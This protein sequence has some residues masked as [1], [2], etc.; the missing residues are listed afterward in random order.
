MKCTRGYFGDYKFDRVRCRVFLAGLILVSLVLP[1]LPAYGANSWYTSV[2]VDGQTV[3]VSAFVD[4]VIPPSKVDGVTFLDI[5]ISIYKKF[6]DENYPSGDND[7]N[8]QGNPGSVEQDIYEEIIQFMAD[9]VY[10][11]TDG[12]HKLR[13]VCIYKKG[14]RSS[15]ADIIWDPFGIP[16]ATRSGVAGAG[17]HIYMYDSFNGHDHLVDKEGAGYGLAHNVGHYFYGLET[18]FPQQSGDVGVRFSIMNNPWAAR[19]GNYSWLNF[20]VAWRDDPPGDFEDTKLSE[21][22]RYFFESCWE[23]IARDPASDPKPSDL[24]GAFKRPYYT[25]LAMVAPVG[26]AK[27]TVDLPVVGT[28]TSR[29]DLNIIWKTNDLVYQIVLDRSGSMS[30]TKVENAKTAAKLLVGKAEFGKSSIGIVIFD[31]VVEVLTPITLIADQT[32]KD[33]IAL[34]IDT[35]TAGGSTAVGDAAQ[36]AL[37]GLTALGTTDDTKI[38]FLLSDGQSNSGVDPL[39]VIPAYQ[40]AKIPIFSFAYGS[41][42]DTVTLGQMATDT[43]GELFISPTS[44]ADVTSAFERAFQLASGS[45]SISS[46]SGVAQGAKA[47]V[48]NFFVIDSTVGRL[49]LSVVHDGA[50]ADTQ[51][52]LQAPTGAVVAPTLVSESTS[53]TLLLYTVDLPLTGLWTITVTPLVASDVGFTYQ[54][55][56]IPDGKQYS[57]SLESW[58]GNELV[59]PAPMLLVAALER[60]LPINGASVLG[61]LTRPSGARSGITLRDDGEGVDETANDGRYSALVIYDASGLYSIDIDADNFSG[62]ASLTFDD[63][64]LRP[65][66][67]GSDSHEHEDDPIEEFFQREAS[68]QLQVTGTRADDHGNSYSSAT[69]VVADNS[70]TP[71]RI[72]TLSDVD[73]FSFTVPPGEF[74]LNVRV[75]GLAGGIAPRLRVFDTNGITLLR[76]GTSENATGPG[77]YVN[78][79]FGVVAAGTTYYAS[80]SNDATVG[81][82]YQFSAGPDIKA[83]SDRFPPGAARNFMAVGEDGVVSL[84]WTEP[85]DIDLAGVRIIR[86]SSGFP[87][88]PADG[89]P[90][91]NGLKSNDEDGA[92]AKGGFFVDT[93]VANDITYYYGAFAYDT[94][95]NF[96]PGVY[97][98]ATPT[99][100]C[101]IAT[102]A[103]GSPLAA[104]LYLFRSFRDQYLMTNVVGEKLVAFYYATSPP[105]ADTIAAHAVLRIPVRTGLSVV[106]FIL[107]GFMYAPYTFLMLG[108]AACAFYVRRRG[109]RKWNVALHS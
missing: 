87:A 103:Y 64:G 82:L 65:P 5:V 109:S 100:P 42:A 59:Y 17:G 50:A 3:P 8:T 62:T 13:N 27:P 4:R 6:G 57:L 99:A 45:Q 101:F 90:V 12:Q 70:D 108:V 25:D 92:F 19:G 68:M 107:R 75:S 79:R 32:T 97:A 53:E 43:G 23:T 31:N 33:D 66:P 36:I 22:H 55:T 48:E 89:Q 73:F 104:D 58:G 106:A 102:A 60:E 56:S 93:A 9:G 20:S 11:S 54:A 78:L 52:T 39:S 37:D 80:V 24:N 38:V 10:E 83:D 26:F 94:S 40:S 98:S 85:T 35:I 18:E 7:G 47:S 29:S 72:E 1:T 51:I 46:E 30:G 74:R 76:E 49:D 16:H 2:T 81:G 61:V 71:G 44:L 14:K 77:G 28:E 15:E 84:L 34:Q 88:H 96:A 41:S 105:L 95:Q 63:H 86:N 21:H 91:F 69:S 67:G